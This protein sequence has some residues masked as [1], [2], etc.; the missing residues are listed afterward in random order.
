MDKFENLTREDTIGLLT[1]ELKNAQ[2]HEYDEDMKNDL[3][4]VYVHRDSL[5]VMLGPWP[6]LICPETYKLIENNPDYH[7]IKFGALTQH[8]EELNSDNLRN[9]IKEVEEMDSTGNNIDLLPKIVYRGKQLEIC[10]NPDGP[11]EIDLTV[12]TPEIDLES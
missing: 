11:K 5:K 6:H 12:E 9:Y 2:N 3:D 10:A 1:R 4:K 7:Q 8:L